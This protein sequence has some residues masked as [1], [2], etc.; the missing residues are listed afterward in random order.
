[1]DHQ[2]TITILS[3]SSNHGGGMK[4]M[5]IRKLVYTAAILFLP[6]I[7]MGGSCSTDPTYSGNFTSTLNITGNYRVITTP[8]STLNNFTL[9]QTNNLLQGV[10]N[11][12]TVYQGT[13]TENISSLNVDQSANIITISATMQG[14][15]GSGRVIT[16]IITQVNAGGFG[17]PV[18]TTDTSGTSDSPTL[19]VNTQPSQT[20]NVSNFIFIQSLVGTYTDS[21]GVAGSFEMINNTVQSDVVL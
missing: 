13:V 1:M 6:L 11:L 19:Q 20:T 10:D 14:T 17:F 3:K 21:L 15:D 5:V 4:Q 8:N 16:I 2:Y 18:D 12:G 9:T 7:L